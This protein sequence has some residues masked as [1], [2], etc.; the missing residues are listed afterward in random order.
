MQRLYSGLWLYHNRHLRALFHVN[1]CTHISL[2]RCVVK[3]V[4]GMLG[5]QTL[6]KPKA[7]SFGPQ[8]LLWLQVFFISAR[9]Y[10]DKLLPRA[11]IIHH[12]QTWWWKMHNLEFIFSIISINNHQHIS[13]DSVDCFRLVGHLSFHGAINPPNRNGSYCSITL[14][15]GEDFTELMFST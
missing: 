15:A 12:F 4:C 9:F 14:H 11:S 2:Q 6:L 13:S 7:F 8:F 3:L 10:L 1:C 5:H